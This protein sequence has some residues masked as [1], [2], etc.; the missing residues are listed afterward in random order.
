MVIRQKKFGNELT[1]TFRPDAVNYALRDSTGSREVDV[2]Y[3]DIPKKPGVLIEQ[4]RWLLNVGYLWGVLGLLQVAFALFAGRDLAGVAFWLVLGGG[5]IAWS[6]L[7]TVRY[8]VFE[9]P[10]GAL[11]VIQG[12]EHHDRIV[13]ELGERKKQQLLAWYDGVETDKP[14]DHQ[15]AK[16]RWL[17]D[18]GVLTATEV[19]ARIALVHE[20]LGPRGSTAPTTLN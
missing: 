3:A 2:P 12:D 4:N 5:C 17:H 10:Q 1:F 19:D 16:F 18:Q 14:I 8:T 13:E 15:I 20:K 6:R 7:R 9:T 11:Y